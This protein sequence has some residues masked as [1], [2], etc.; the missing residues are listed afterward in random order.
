VFAF[1]ELV[2][3][4]IQKMRRCNIKIYVMNVEAHKLEISSVDGVRDGEE[5]CEKKGRRM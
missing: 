3:V 1:I 4:T 2:R 5:R